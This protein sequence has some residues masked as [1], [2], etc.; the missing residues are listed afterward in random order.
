VHRV[1]EVVNGPG[2]V[3]DAGPLGPRA[4]CAEAN[5]TPTGVI[6]VRVPRGEAE[7]ASR[8]GHLI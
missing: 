2:S 4:A 3:R 7:L 6:G 5:T 8:G 1:S